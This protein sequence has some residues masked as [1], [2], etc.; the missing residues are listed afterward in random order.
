MVQPAKRSNVMKVPSIYMV[1]EETDEAK[2]EKILVVA[3][4]QADWKNDYVIKLVDE[5][6]KMNQLEEH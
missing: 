4:C 1:Q 2:V 5:K 3:D 6:L